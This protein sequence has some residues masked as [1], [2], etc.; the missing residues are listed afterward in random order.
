MSCKPRAAMFYM[1]GM[2]NDMNALDRIVE[3]RYAAFGLGA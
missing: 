2:A 3:C 1:S